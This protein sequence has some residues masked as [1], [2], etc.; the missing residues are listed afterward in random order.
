MT[1]AQTHT[2]TRARA[3]IQ[4]TENIFLGSTTVGNVSWESRV[5]WLAL[6]CRTFHRSHQHITIDLVRPETW[7]SRALVSSFSSSL[8]SSYASSSFS[9]RPDIV[10]YL[11]LWPLEDLH[12]LHDL[13]DGNRQLWNAENKSKLSSMPIRKICHATFALT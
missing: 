5:L 4:A 7:G 6:R 9:S 8:P 13:K 2:H 1:R 10:L 3:R 12:V 11:H